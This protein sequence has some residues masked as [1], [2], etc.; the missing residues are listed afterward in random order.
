MRGNSQKKHSQLCE[1]SV[2]M[3]PKIQKYQMD[4]MP[5]TKKS[6][7]KGKKVTFST[8]IKLARRLRSPT[9]C[10]WDRSRKLDDMS[11]YIKDESQEVIDAFKAK[12]YKNLQEELG[13]ILFNIVLTAEI[14]DEMGKFDMNDVLDGI[15]KKIRSR[16]TWVFGKDRAHTP[17]EALEMWKKNKKREQIKKKHEAEE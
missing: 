12:D 5:N 8:L 6:S 9:G 15:D 14:A 11:K 17:E 1:A 4:S 10:P 3:V 2:N 16:H 7:I 13:D